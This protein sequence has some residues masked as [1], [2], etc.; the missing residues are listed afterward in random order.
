MAAGYQNSI[1]TKE[2][3][4]MANFSNSSGSLTY[5]VTVLIPKCIA[6][7]MLTENFSQVTYHCN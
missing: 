4:I 5:I 7:K 6:F 3:V 2:I 1:L